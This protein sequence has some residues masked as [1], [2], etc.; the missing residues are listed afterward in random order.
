MPLEHQLCL[1]GMS[2]Q[3][4]RSITL[5]ALGSNQFT[6]GTS[7]LARLKCGLDMLKSRGLVPVATSPFYRSEPLGSVRQPRFVNAVVAVSSA[8]P[9]GKLLR[10]VKNIER[11]MGRRIGVRWGPRTLD[12]DIISHRGQ[13]CSGRGLGW[14]DRKGRP[15]VRRRGQVVLPHPEAHLRAFVLRPLCDVMPHWHHPVLNRTA[16]QLF[17][18]LPP[19]RQSRLVRLTVDIN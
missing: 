9:I 16:I 6:E 11:A 3:R 5:L 1:T 14:V 12:I 19:L 4:N 17:H 7:P 2:T 8:E 13:Y 10:I 18:R 15:T